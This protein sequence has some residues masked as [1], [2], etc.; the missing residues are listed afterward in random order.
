MDE[1]TRIARFEAAYNRIDRALSGIVSTGGGRASGR[2]VGGAGGAGRRKHGFAAKVRIAAQRRRH[3]ARHAD[4]LL[5]IG[6][7]RNAIVHNRTGDDAYL[8]APTEQTVLELE[9][10]E[11]AAFS[12]EK[13][14]PRF[15]AQVITLR[16]EQSM[17]DAWTLMRDDGFTRYPVYDDAEFVGLLTSNGFA[18]WVASRLKGAIIEFDAGQ[19]RVADLL[20]KD[21]RRERVRFV[22]R[23]VLIDDVDEL[24]AEV[25]GLEAVIIT[26]HGKPH[27]RPLGMICPS[28]IAGWGR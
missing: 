14:L 26:E 2:G 19:V 16:P 20:A 23:D 22:S 28:D 27:E 7:L 17:V 21:H 18:R 12:P 4:F 11:Q 5:E 8:A 24:F 10:I 25:K 15:A 6:E 3:F 9:R 1:P 13:V